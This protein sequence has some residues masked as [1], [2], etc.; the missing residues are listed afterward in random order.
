MRPGQHLAWV[1]AQGAQL[2]LDFVETH[3]V[4]LAVQTPA[5]LVAQQLL[6][7]VLLAVRIAPLAAP[8]QQ[9]PA[10]L[11]MSLAGL[12]FASAPRTA[13][14]R[15]P[16]QLSWLLVQMLLAVLAVLVVPSAAQA[17]ASCLAVLVI[18]VAAGLAVGVATLAP[19]SAV[20]VMLRLA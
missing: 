14:Y 17:A 11:G 3:A 1:A 10:T 5:P 18:P 20:A 19:L 8:S 7:A 2:Q 15:P 6:K 16:T 4:M 13:A 12:R 9:K